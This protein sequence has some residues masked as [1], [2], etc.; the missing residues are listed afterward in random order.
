MKRLM[1]RKNCSDETMKHLTMLKNLSDE[2][3]TASSPRFITSLLHRCQHYINP[4]RKRHK[5]G[6][7]FLTHK[8]KDDDVLRL[9][10]ENY[11]NNKFFGEIANGIPHFIASMH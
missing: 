4:C 2:T 11:R 7:N 9:C 10:Y 1:L 3:F 6:Q 8:G 5:T